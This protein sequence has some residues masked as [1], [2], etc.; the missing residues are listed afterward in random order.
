MR[1]FSSRIFLFL[2]ISSLMKKGS[3][4]NGIC[5][6]VSCISSPVYEEKGKCEEDS[7]QNQPIIEKCR[8]FWVKRGSEGGVRGENDNFAVGIIFP[9]I[10]LH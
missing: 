1:I 5:C 3:V 2:P 7:N 6:N 8:D 4:K 9:Y 10:S